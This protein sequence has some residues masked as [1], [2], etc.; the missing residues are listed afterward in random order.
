MSGRK[1]VGII[2][3]RLSGTDGVSLETTKWVRILAELG[4]VCYF[5]TAESQWP[6]EKTYLVP[7]VH[8]NH[9]DIQA[10]N[11]DLFDNF[12]R[13]DEVSSTIHRLARHIKHHLVQFNRQFKPDIL[14]A[15][16]C[17]SLPMNVPLGLALTEFIIETGIVT[18]AHHHD[19]SW[20]RT[21]F[22]RS[23]ADDLLRAAFPPTAR[24]IRHV[25]INSYAQNQLALRTGASSKLIPNVMDFE[26]PPD[27]QDKFASDLRTRLGIK[28][29]TYLLLQPTRIVPRKRIELAIEFTRRLE[30]PCALII[31]H[32]SGDEENTYEEY[33]REY[34]RL[35]GVEVFFASNIFAIQRSLTSD[36]GKIYSLADAYQNAD[37]VTYP[38][39]IEGFGNAFL[40]AIYY[41]RPLV[42]NMYEIFYTDIEPKGFDVIVFQDFIDGKC[43]HRARQI[44]LDPHQAREMTDHNYRIAQKYYSYS[45]LKDQLSALMHECFGM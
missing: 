14:I 34:S 26:N 31:S 35:L 45:M 23:G 15:E 29:E 8:F 33:L 30:L 11:R 28:D 37:L 12:K 3:T 42:M 25:V 13:S 39:V 21:R 6:K 32:K 38:S 1:R 2:A 18:I 19:F 17:L 20:E 40:E 9:P 24:Q 7:E 43:I 4:Y 16:N 22:A 5:F 41:Q 44:L 36:G 10:I 27:I